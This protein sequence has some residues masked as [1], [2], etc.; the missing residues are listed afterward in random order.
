MAYGR[1][2]KL[3]SKGVKRP[4]SY[5]LSRVGK[6]AR[7]A[8]SVARMARK[9]YTK[10]RKWLKP[11]RTSTFNSGYSITNMKAKNTAKRSMRHRRTR[12]RDL[13]AALASR[14]SVNY[15]RINEIEVGRGA[16]LLPNIGF[17]NSTQDLNYVPLHIFSLDK[18]PL[19]SNSTTARIGWQLYH[20]T[21]LPGGQ[22]MY[23]FTSSFWS[24]NVQD[25]DVADNP[26]YVLGAS[27]IASLWT[28]RADEAGT[29]ASIWNKAKWYQ[30]RVHVEMVMYGQTNA[31]TLYR[32]DI[33][34]LDPRFAQ[35]FNTVNETD[36]VFVAAGQQVT[37]EW[38]SFWHS[39]VAPYTQ[40]PLHKP[41][42]QKG[43]IKIV[44]SFKFKIPEQ[45]ADFDRIPCVKT[46]FTIPMDRVVNYAWRKGVDFDGQ[47]TNP[48]DPEDV[49]IMNFQKSDNNPNGAQFSRGLLHPAASYFMIVRATNTDRG[50]NLASF[51]TT[52]AVNRGQDPTYDIKMRSEY[53][54][55]I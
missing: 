48:V 52:V 30:K 46:K 3:Q 19:L 40:N 32:V 13:A 29:T 41:Q 25:G 33:V 18:R 51:P 35:A 20:D 23:K 9:S 42:R 22:Q 43:A 14:V 55:D 11:K 7:T 27:N 24:K 34:K 39:I 50:A 47:I 10:V 5:S 38:N 4:A 12:K 31:D 2:R 28:D 36:D 26:D 54:V 37:D 49:T 6:Y 44:K 15:T 16:L 8:Y 21:A 1:R 17:A 45:S 53:L